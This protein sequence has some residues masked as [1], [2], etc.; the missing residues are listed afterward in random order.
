MQALET[1]L[2]A[3]EVLPCSCCSHTSI[4]FFYQPL[5]QKRVTEMPRSTSAHQCRHI[6]LN[7]LPWIQDEEPELQQMHEAQ[8]AQR[9]SVLAVKHRSLHVMAPWFRRQKL[10]S[11]RTPMCEPEHTHH[12]QPSPFCLSTRRSR[13]RATSTSLSLPRER[14]SA[15]WQRGCLLINARSPEGVTSLRLPKKPGSLV[16]FD[17]LMCLEEAARSPFRKARTG[18]WTKGE[19]AL[20]LSS[21]VPP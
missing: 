4:Q 5:Y 9:E 8:A 19:K 18:C 12:L 10:R 13:R 14:A 16:T 15:S 1:L 17:K 3:S 20:S 6:S 11:H 21:G 7:R 2:T